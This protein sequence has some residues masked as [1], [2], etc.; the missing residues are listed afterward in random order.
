[1]TF[2]RITL[3]KYNIILNMLFKYWSTW[4]YLW[5]IGYRVGY[6]NESNGLKTSVLLTSIV[7]GYIIYIYPKK[8]IIYRKNRYISIPRNVLILCDFV[9]HQIPFIDLFFIERK[10]IDHSCGLS[11]L[12]PFT[13]WLG[14]NYFNSC[15]FHKIYGTNIY[16]LWGACATLLI[17]YGTYYHMIETKRFNP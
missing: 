16:K 17:G 9:F 3:F 11:I 15:K 2:V 10:R 4:N 5:Y 12:V 13:G 14:Y 6:V 7:G 1:M 8:I